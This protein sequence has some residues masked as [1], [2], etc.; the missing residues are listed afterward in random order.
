MHTWPP[1]ED[2]STHGQ[3]I[4]KQMH[5]TM[6][7]AGLSFLAAQFLLALF[8][9]QYGGRGQ[10]DKIKSLPGGAKGLV[11]AALVLV[12]SEIIVLGV[13]GQKAWANVYFAPPNKDALTIQ[14]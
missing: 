14:A 11:I 12:G 9:W 1:P 7:E 10:Q 13:I 6:Y 3:A 4:D 8:I 2:I 5:D